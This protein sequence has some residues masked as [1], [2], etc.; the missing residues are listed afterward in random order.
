[1]QCFFKLV[2]RTSSTYWDSTVT[3]IIIWLQ[4]LLSE[5][6]YPSVIKDVTNRAW[7]MGSIRN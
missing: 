5:Y 4:S 6:K 7:S 3:N 2:K 1:M